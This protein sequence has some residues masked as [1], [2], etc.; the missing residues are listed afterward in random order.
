[1]YGINQAQQDL[2]RNK[3]LG[4]GML[5]PDSFAED[6]LIL[7][8]PASSALLVIFSRNHNYIA[9]N[10]LKINERGRWSDPPPSDPVKRLLQDEE[11]FQ[12]ARLVKYAPF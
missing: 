6:R 9:D 3:D 10:L 5:Y 1:M 12:V 7:V 2:V 11:I 4:R 8:P